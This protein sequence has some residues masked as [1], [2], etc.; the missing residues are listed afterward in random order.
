MRGYRSS[1]TD[2]TGER[3]TYTTKDQS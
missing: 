2:P 1:D 3:L